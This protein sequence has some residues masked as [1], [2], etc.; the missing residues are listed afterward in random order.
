[1]AY[2]REFHNCNI[3]SDGVRALKGTP[4]RVVRPQKSSQ[5]NKN[6]KQPSF[7]NHTH[8]ESLASMNPPLGF[9]FL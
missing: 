9:V 5:V 6:S 7:I 1:M 8:S 4:Q 2:H 3:L